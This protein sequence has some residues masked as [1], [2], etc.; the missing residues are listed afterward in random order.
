MNFPPATSTPAV[1]NQGLEHGVAAPA[2]IKIASAESELELTGRTPSKQPENFDQVAAIGASGSE[3]REHT[4]KLRKRR[5]SSKKFRLFSQ[6]QG[7]ARAGIFPSGLKP[8]AGCQE[9]FGANSEAR[10]LSDQRLSASKILAHRMRPK[11]LQSKVVINAFR[12]QSFLHQP[13]AR[14]RSKAFGFPPPATSS[15]GELESG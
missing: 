1:P 7:K 14:H 3:W 13:A 9:G 11:A 5:V 10:V 8:P 4:Q 6:R 12:H 2:A 15:D